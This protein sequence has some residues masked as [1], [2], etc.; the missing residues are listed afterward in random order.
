MSCGNVS[1]RGTNMGVAI[2][3]KHAWISE[4]QLVA[5]HQAQLVRFRKR[6]MRNQLLVQSQ[7]PAH[8]KIVLALKD[9]LHAKNKSR[10]LRRD[11]IW[12]MKCRVHENT[13]PCRHLHRTCDSF[14]ARSYSASILMSGL[15]M[16]WY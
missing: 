1:K 13:G 3:Q 4:P 14:M 8:S 10:A 9:E 11:L 6:E 2:E 16:F 5:S 15:K 12:E 7:H